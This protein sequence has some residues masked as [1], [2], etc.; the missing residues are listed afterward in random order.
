M[1]GHSKWSQIKRKKAVLDAKRGAHFTKLIREI[2]VAARE[3]GGDVEGNPRL[4]TAVQT[5]KAANMP[6]DNVERAIKKGTGEIEG[7]VYEETVYEGYGP[8]GAA[9]IVEVTTDNINRTVA[10]IRHI[11]SKRGGNLGTANSVAWMFERKGQFVVN[12]RSH[13]EE[14]VMEAAI[15]AGS[16]DFSVDGDSYIITTEPSDLHVV[17]DKVEKMG[18]ETADAEI[19]MIPSNTVQ[20]E[21]KEAHQLLGLM[22]ALDEQDDVSRIHSNFDI[23]G[24]TLAAM[25]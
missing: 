1:S 20:V 12:A 6:A 8:G 5:A 15:N 3:G 16:E 17:Q 10:E 9:I 13:D 22:E 4:R 11:F 21:G 24:D 2:T 19:A 25:E 18:I 14:K 23:D 7:V